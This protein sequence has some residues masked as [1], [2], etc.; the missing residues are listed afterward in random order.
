MKSAKVYREKFRAKTETF[1][2]K[3][4]YRAAYTA[5]RKKR[6]RIMK[7]RVLRYNIAV[8]YLTL[9]LWVFRCSDGRVT[10]RA[11]HGNDIGLL[12]RLQRRLQSVFYLLHLSFH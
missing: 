12:R 3:R 10:L 7:T 11:K 1:G 5:K 6:S 2:G 4:N 9:M 8:N